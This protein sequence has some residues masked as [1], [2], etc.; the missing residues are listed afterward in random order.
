[1]SK[2]TRIKINT[3]TLLLPKENNIYHLI[4]HLQNEIQVQKL[5]AVAIPLTN[6]Y[7][8]SPQHHTEYTG[9]IGCMFLPP[10]TFSALCRT[11]QQYN[12]RETHH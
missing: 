2:D 10:G 12:N 7:R 3:N 4:V 6:F 8:E 1:M 5:N 9:I 11:A